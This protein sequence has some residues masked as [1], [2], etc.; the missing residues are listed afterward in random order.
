M[1]ALLSSLMFLLALGACSTTTR[2]IQDDLVEPQNV[3]GVGL[4]TVRFDYAAWTNTNAKDLD[5]AKENEAE[6]SQRL[7]TAFQAEAT[8]LGIAGAGENAAKVDITITDLDPGSR[9]KRMWVGFGAGTGRIR[10]Q[11]EVGGHGSFQLDGQI[12]GGAW[13]GDFGHVLD[14]LGTNIAKHLAQ[15]VGKPTA[16]G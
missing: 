1:K 8:K 11:V 10:S 7:G 15:R 9:A 6:W 14:A 4:G 12:K 5:T 3:H 16:A 2:L 13:G